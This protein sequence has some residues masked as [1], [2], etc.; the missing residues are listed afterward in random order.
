MDKAPSAR[1]SINR[2]SRSRIY[3]RQADG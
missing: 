2:V 1:R 3:K